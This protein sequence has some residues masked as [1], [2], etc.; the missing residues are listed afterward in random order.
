MQI[1]SLILGLITTWSDGLLV[2]SYIPLKW[3]DILGLQ[4]H[5][6]SRNGKISRQWFLTGTCC[7]FILRK[8]N[9]S[10]E[11]SL[12]GRCHRNF[13]IISSMHF[14]IVYTCN[15]LHLLFRRLKVSCLTF[16]TFFKIIFCFDSSTHRCKTKFGKST[17][18]RGVA[19]GRQR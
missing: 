17:F 18:Q 15:M 16:R 4:F 9:Y 14:S 5:W 19:N 7:I 6:K 11:E 1:C 8:N 2:Q 10:V 3:L 12:V 13:S